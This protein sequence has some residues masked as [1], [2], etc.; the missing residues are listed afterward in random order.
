MAFEKRTIGPW[1]LEWD[2]NDKFQIYH[3]HPQDR[4]GKG[5]FHLALADKEDASKTVYFCRNCKE[6][7]PAGIV[8][9]GLTRRLVKS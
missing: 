1:D 5:R 2:G 3:N 9:A 8:T 6:K 4:D 7:V